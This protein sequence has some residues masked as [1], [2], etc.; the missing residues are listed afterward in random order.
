MRSRQH[1][2]RTTSR[3]CVAEETAQTIAIA[4]AKVAK[5]PVYSENFSE[6]FS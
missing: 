2:I 5:N 3:R 4:P 6:N 1:P